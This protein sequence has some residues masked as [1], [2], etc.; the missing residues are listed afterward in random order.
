MRSYRGTESDTFFSMAKIGIVCDDYKL[1]MFKEELD[2]AN[3]VY[4]VKSKFTANSVIITCESEQ[5]IIK[6]IVDKVTQ[7]FIDKYK[8]LN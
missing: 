4:T 3:I 6:P 7:Y 8:K 2:A 1:K 5:H